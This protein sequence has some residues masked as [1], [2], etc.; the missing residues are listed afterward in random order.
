MIVFDCELVRRLRGI[1]AAEQLDLSSSSPK[2]GRKCRQSL[3]S[4][5]A[6]EHELQVA[7]YVCVDQF[8]F[9]PNTQIARVR[10]GT[11]FPTFRVV[12]GRC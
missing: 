10:V 3:A 12:N 5:L 2:V 4:S 8:K 1:Y 11:D 9:C 6:C 7:S